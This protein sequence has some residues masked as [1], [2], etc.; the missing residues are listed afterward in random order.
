MRLFPGM[1]LRVWREI[2]PGPKRFSSLQRPCKL[3]GLQGHRSLLD[4]AEAGF[5]LV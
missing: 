3:M 4:A 2:L 5:L 1:R